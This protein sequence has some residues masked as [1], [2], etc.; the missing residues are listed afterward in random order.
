MP[1]FLPLA[2]LGLLWKPLFEGYWA[3]TWRSAHMMHKGWHG[4]PQ[5]AIGCKRIW[6]EMM[7]G[8][9]EACDATIN[10]MEATTAAVYNCCFLLGQQQTMLSA[11]CVGHALCAHAPLLRQCVCNT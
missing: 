2:L 5:A 11:Y 9:C 7:V 10:G 8:A 1:T 4:G 3:N 6:A